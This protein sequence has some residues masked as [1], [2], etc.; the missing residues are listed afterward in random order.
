MRGGTGPIAIA[1]VAVLLILALLSMAACG[2]RAPTFF[3]RADTANPCPRPANLTGS[4]FNAQETGIRALRR[5]AFRGDFFAQLELG[6]RYAAQ[7]ATDKNL[8][9]PIESSVWLAMALA[10]ED[11]FAPINR[12]ERGMFGGWRPLSKYDDCRAWERQN[13]YQRLNSQLSRM[14]LTEQEEVRD[15][16]IYVLSTQGADGYRTLARLHDALSGAFGEPRTTP[17]PAK[18]SA[19]ARVATAAAGAIPPR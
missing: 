7:R 3:R 19:G 10:N 1:A 4:E 6:G 14:T 13:A 2:E 9:D 8:E 16:V 15:R 5:A 17:R 11:G 12:V 18:R